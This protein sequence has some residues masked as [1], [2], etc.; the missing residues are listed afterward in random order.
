MK[1][2]PFIGVVT[3]LSAVPFLLFLTYFTSQYQP[4]LAHWFVL[5]KAVISVSGI[6]GGVFLWRR[7]VWGYRIGLF[8][9]VLIAVSSIASLVSLYQTSG[10][11]DVSGTVATIWMSKE[12]I[13]ILIAAPVLYVLIRDLIESKQSKSE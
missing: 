3:L 11:P 13:Y 2:R 4:P 5:E 6:V 7:N 10:Q 1:K 12:V 9:W 8:A